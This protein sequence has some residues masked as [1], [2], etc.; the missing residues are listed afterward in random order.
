MTFKYLPPPRHEM[1]PEAKASLRR[2]RLERRMKQRTVQPH[3]G[4]SERAKRGLT[5]YCLNHLTDEGR[6][7]DM[8]LTR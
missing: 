5:T 7:L 3:I 4:G 2:K 1:T 8:L 6:F